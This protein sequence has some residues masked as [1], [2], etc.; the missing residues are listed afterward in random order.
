MYCKNFI[1]PFTPTDLIV[2][3]NNDES[4][5]LSGYLYISMLCNLV[6]TEMNPKATSAEDS[7]SAP[8]VWEG[9]SLN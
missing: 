2:L 6:R 9:I 1:T 8:R 3:E 5:R 4:P 7:A